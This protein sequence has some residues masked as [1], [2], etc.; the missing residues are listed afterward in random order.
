RE[1]TTIAGRFR[2][3]I[4]ACIAD[5]AEGALVLARGEPG[6]AVAPLMRAC[7]FWS[8]FGAPYLVGRLRVELARCYA[9]L[10]DREGAERELDAAGKIFRQLEAAPDLAQ[11]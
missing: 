4:L 7:R 10:G 2:T 11:I 6:A 8:Q 3:E 5:Q 9:G 1:L